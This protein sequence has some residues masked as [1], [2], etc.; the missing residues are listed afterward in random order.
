MQKQNLPLP[1]K[2]LRDPSP[3]LNND[4]TQQNNNPFGYTGYQ[5]DNITG[6]YYAQ[7]RYYDPAVDRFGA[8]D[9]VRN[10]LNWYVY[11]RA[12]PIR[13]VDKNGLWDDEH[14]YITRIAGDR[15]GLCDSIVDLLIFFNK[16][17]DNGY[18]SPFP[19][20]T[21]G[22]HFNFGAYTSQRN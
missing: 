6:L 21:Y 20:G 8:E 13:F 12:N 10:G 9:I 3:P 19:G 17:T 5:T 18:T 15:V 22:L 7:A 2:P 14:Y 1:A 4:S 11:C 16:D